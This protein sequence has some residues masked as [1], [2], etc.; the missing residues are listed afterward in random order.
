MIKLGKAPARQ[1]LQRL[2]GQ[3]TLGEAGKKDAS[4]YRQ[5][6]AVGCCASAWVPLQLAPAAPPGS[7]ICPLQGCL[8][9]V[10]S[11]CPTWGRLLGWGAPGQCRGTEEPW[12]RGCP[13]QSPW[14]PLAPGQVCSHQGQCWGWGCS[15]LPAAGGEPRGAEGLAPV[16]RMV[17]AERAEGQRQSVGQ[18][19]GK[20]RWW[21]WAGVAWAGGS[22]VPRMRR[23]SHS[24]PRSPAEPVRAG[25][26]CCGTGLWEPLGGNTSRTAVLG[27]CPRSAEVAGAEPGC[28][29]RA[30]TLRLGSGVS[31]WV[32]PLALGF[33]CVPTAP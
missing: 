28:E 11:R 6:G 30:L 15:G 1:R 20:E 12:E 13:G 14:R 18:G 27:G 23:A 22:G 21:Q 31:E 16:I 33:S 9:P 2:A 7:S 32:Q 3:A 4:F 5:A 19:R 29:T 26:P 17:W 8:P 25:G 10:P 24:A